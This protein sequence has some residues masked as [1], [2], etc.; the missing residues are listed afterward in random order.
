MN[1]ELLSAVLLGATCLSASWVIIYWHLATG[2]TWREWPAGRSLM[3][4]LGIIA[5]GF[6]FGMVN[7][8]IP[9]PLGKTFV[10]VGLYALFVG[11]IIFIGLTIRRE[12]RVGRSKAQHPASTHSPATGS[13]DLPVATDKE[14]SDD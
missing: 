10:G 2:G 6:G 4:L 13:I 7:R 14:P 1:N 5:V 11:S 3:G 8:I 12:L 9:F